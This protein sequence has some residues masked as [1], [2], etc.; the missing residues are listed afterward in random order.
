MLAYA[1][2]Q[3]HRTVEE[4]VEEVQRCKAEGFKAYKI[5]PP[6]A[7]QPGGRVD[8]KLDM[9]VAKAV[10]KAA[11]DDFILLMD[12]VGV[13]TR[14]EAIKVGRLL[15]ELNY[16]AYEDPIPTT[17]IDGLVELCRA[18]D[19]PIHV[20]EFIFSPYSYAEYIRRQALD[21]VR[22]IVDNIGG[23]TGAMKVAY[24]AECF[25]LECAAQLGDGLDHAV[26]FHC[27]L[28]MPN[29]VWFEMTVP[30]GSSD[31]PY[32][33]DRI[34]IAKD[35]YVDARPSPDWDTKLIATFSTR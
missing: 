35:G 21:V 5:H 18:L 2:S 9:E 32:M 13:Y 10:R 16:V 15:D 22:L 24:A 25:G 17:D 14:E 20:G 31:R 34:R 7:K 6:D 26:H 3:H 30:Q 1:S 33:K 28:A 27:E 12:P 29:N 8:F 19:V 11:G 4:F 23:I